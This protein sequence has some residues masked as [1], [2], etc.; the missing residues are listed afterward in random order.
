MKT[1][2]EV[3]HDADAI[4]AE[5]PRTS[6]RVAAHRQ[7]VLEA[8]PG[9]ADSRRRFSFAMAAAIAAV[10]VGTGAFG[11][12]RIGIDARAAVRFAAYLAE[13]NYAP[14][15]R[16]LT[17]AGTDRKLYLHT[18]PV[19]E[20][21]DVAKANVVEGATPSAFG[22]AVTFTADGAERMLRAT[23]DHINR[24]LAIFID[25]ELVAAPMVRAVITSQALLSGTLTRGEAQRIADGI[26]GR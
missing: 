23:E 3:L 24:P 20:N 16:E 10:V 4:A 19:V 8:R 22:V 21:V 7:K 5:G 13:D 15:L 25:G 2:S 11:W 26:I 17:V 18:E 12:L 6:A 14:G 1:L 9:L